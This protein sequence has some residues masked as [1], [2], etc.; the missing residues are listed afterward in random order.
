MFHRNKPNYHQLE[1]CP[2][3]PLGARMLLVGGSSGGKTYAVASMLTNH[4]F[5]QR[6]THIYLVRKVHQALYDYMVR[7]YPH[8]FFDELAQFNF[9]AALPDSVTIVDDSNYEVQQSRVFYELMKVA[10]HSNLT[11]LTMSP[12]V[13]ATGRFSKDQ[14]ELYT[15]ILLF[16]SKWKHPPKLFTDIEDQLPFRT[17]MLNQLVQRIPRSVLILD[18]DNERPY[19]IPTAIATMFPVVV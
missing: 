4:L 9:H 8:T 16:H 18:V 10:R 7:G 13:Y 6:P 2:Q 17:K 11:I 14:R 1:P 3:I 19:H 12:R 5:S 15:K